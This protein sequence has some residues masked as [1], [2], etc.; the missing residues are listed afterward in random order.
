MNTRE[1]SDLEL[2]EEWRR[3][4]RQQEA[5]CKKRGEEKDDGPYGGLVG[6]LVAKDE[7]ALQYQKLSARIWDIKWA[8]FGD[9][10]FSA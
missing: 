7:L 3:L 2:L 4:L 5:L 10:Q 9:L 1:M 8:L 6:I